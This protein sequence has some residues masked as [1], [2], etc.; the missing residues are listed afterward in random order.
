MR[1]GMKM[2]R[3][4][5]QE[6]RVTPGGLQHPVILDGGQHTP[7]TL[8]ARMSV[9]APWTFPPTR[10]YATSTWPSL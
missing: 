3:M 2:S 1:A 5:I 10:K 4:T 8:K 9:A 7:H 6:A